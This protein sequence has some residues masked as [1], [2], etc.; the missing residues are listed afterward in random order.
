MAL[1]QFFHVIFQ[2]QCEQVWNSFFL[3]IDYFSIRE[4][5]LCHYLNC[6]NIMMWSCWVSVYNLN[7]KIYIRKLTTK[8]IGIYAYHVYLNEIVVVFPKESNMLQQKKYFR[9]TYIFYYFFKFYCWKCA[10]KKCLSFLISFVLTSYLISF[11]FGKA[12]KKTKITWVKSRQ[13]SKIINNVLNCI[14]EIK[15]F[16]PKKILITCWQ[17]KFLQKFDFQK[18][19]SLCISCSTK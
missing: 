19:N 4:I 13:T 2:C 5:T 11:F 7:L 17:L 1:N 18:R 10:I 16:H 3:K 8:A 15:K 14:D 12:K 9:S 6:N